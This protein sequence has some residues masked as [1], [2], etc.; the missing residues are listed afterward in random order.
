MAVMAVG[1]RGSV[2]AR[3][4]AMYGYLF[5]SPFL[6]GF[7]IFTAYPVLASLYLS[8]T[9]YNILTPPRWIG[10]ENY[11]EAFTRDPQFWPSLGRTARYTALVVPLGVLA[12]LGAAML[13]NQGFPGTSVFRT[14]FFMPS[15]VP[16][17]ASVLIWIW[18]L[19]PSI[20][21]VNYLLGLLGVAPLTWL[22]STTWALPSLVLIGLWGTAGGSRMVVFLAGLQ[23][24]PRELYEAAEIDGAGRWRRFVSVTVPMISP[25]IFFNLVISIIGAL[26]V[27][28]VAFIGTAG[29]PAYATHFYVYHLYLNAFDYRQMG[30]ASALA[31][32][33]LLLVLALT[34]IQFQLSNR[35]VYYAGD[36]QPERREDG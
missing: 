7:A 8:F 12:S 30:Y 36:E 25:V 33:F 6:V 13:L 16:I 29:G 11:I 1:R 31:W 10:I 5:I 28:S 9:A 18:L 4:R 22:Q 14:F 24:V 27:F 32:V 35:W 17:I 3:R 20:G 19:Q 15:I 21:L 34:V 2:L 26:S 23:G